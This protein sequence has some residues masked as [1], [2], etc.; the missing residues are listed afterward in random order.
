[1][2]AANGY[3]AAEALPVTTNCDGAKR[4]VNGKSGVIDTTFND[5]D[6]PKTG[7]SVDTVM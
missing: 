5:N 7:V 6:M 1:M 3:L 2:F 4:Q